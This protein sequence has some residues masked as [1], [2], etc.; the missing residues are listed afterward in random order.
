MHVISF[1]FSVVH[2]SGKKGL[3]EMPNRE[4]CPSE[5]AVDTASALTDHR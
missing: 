5:T 2:G 1:C 3:G 4:R